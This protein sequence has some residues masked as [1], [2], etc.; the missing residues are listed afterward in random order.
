MLLRTI[1]II[2]A[3]I[4]LVIYFK[5]LNK[6]KKQKKF[7]GNVHPLLVH[8]FGIF[9]WGDALVLAP[10][11]II[12]SLGLII[13]NNTYL[14]I[15]VYAS[16]MFLRQFGEVIYWFLQ[17]F[18]QKKEYRPPDKGWEYLKTD[19]LHI[20]YQLLNFYKSVLWLVVLI[21]AFIFL[22]KSF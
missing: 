14:T 1:L 3:L 9:V 10:F 8:S 22:S 7:Y 15:G 18:S 21:I 2:I 17:Q 4:H 11:F 16:Y 6:V 13:I 19:E 5:A 20:I 12:T